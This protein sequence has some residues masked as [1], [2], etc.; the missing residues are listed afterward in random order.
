MTATCMW[1]LKS[2]AEKQNPVLPQGSRGLSGVSEQD[3]AFV[4]HHPE[5]GRFAR[6]AAQIEAFDD[7]W[8]WN[9]SA[10]A[11]FGDVMRGGNADGYPIFPAINGMTLACEWLA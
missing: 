9:D 6:T 3:D 1:H 7:T 5:P 10:E 4:N 8:H 2:D 11:A